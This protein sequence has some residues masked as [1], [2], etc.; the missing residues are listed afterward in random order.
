MPGQSVGVLG[1]SKS[2]WATWRPGRR[3][4]WRAGGP[5]ENSARAQRWEGTVPRTGTDGQTAASRRSAAGP[6]WWSTAAVQRC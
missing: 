3:A 4:G 1:R 2:G 6:F 5:V